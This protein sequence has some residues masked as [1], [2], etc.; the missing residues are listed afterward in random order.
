MSMTTALVILGLA[1]CFAIGWVVGLAM[2]YFG[3]Q[4][5]IER[6]GYHLEQSQDMTGRTR[7]RLATLHKEWIPPAPG[8]D[9][10]APRR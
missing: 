2:G 9:N 1:A 6:S 4:S 8:T 3:L 5:Q 7:W 10:A